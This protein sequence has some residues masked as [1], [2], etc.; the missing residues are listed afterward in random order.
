MAENGVFE[1]SHSL[2]TSHS[3]DVLK[4]ESLG[5]GFSS[6]PNAVYPALITVSLSTLLFAFYPIQMAYFDDASNASYYS[7]VSGGL[8]PYPPASQTFDTDTGGAYGQY[9]A[10]TDQWGMARWSGPMVGSPTSLREI[11]RFGERHLGSFTHWCLTHE[12]PESEAPTTSY[13]SGTVGHCWPSYDWSAD[14]QQAQSYHSGYLSGDSPFATTAA[15]E[16]STAVQIPSSGEYQLEELGAHQSETVPLNYWGANQSGASTSMFS[17]VDYRVQSSLRNP[18][19]TFP[20]GNLN[21]SRWPRTGPIRADMTQ[22]GW[23]QPYGVS[24]TRPNLYRNAEAGPSTLVAP[25][26]PYI[27]LPTT[28]PSR[29]ISG[30][31]ANATTTHPITEKVRAS[32]SNFYCSHIPRVTEWSFGVRNPSRP[33]SAAGKENPASPVYRAG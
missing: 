23:Y 16:M 6:L 33:G 1:Q 29:G 27:G 14:Y 9:A 25:S 12:P 15:S 11:S 2:A 22:T 26:I 7:S 31:T 10:P 18:A 13:T 4:P 32:V 17:V 3:R 30:R 19:D 8:Y 21:A 5:V 20:Q 28:Q 24:R